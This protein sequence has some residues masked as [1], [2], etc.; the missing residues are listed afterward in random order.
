MIALTV[1]TH[2]IASFDSRRYGYSC[3]RRIL[4]YTQR[5]LMA[6]DLDSVNSFSEPLQFDRYAERK[7][8]ETLV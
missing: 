8:P 2:Y 7:W 1:S 3:F 5:Y 6:Q 4:I